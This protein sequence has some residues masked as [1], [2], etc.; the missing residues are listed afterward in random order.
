MAIA[1]CP[2]CGSPDI[3]PTTANR[4]RNS[5]KC[6][7][8]R[9]VFPLTAT[10]SVVPPAAALILAPIVAQELKELKE[11][12]SELNELGSDMKKWFGGLFANN[13][14]RQKWFGGLFA[15]NQPRPTRRHQPGA[16][17]PRPHRGVPPPSPR[18]PQ[19]APVHGHSPPVSPRTA[20][21]TVAPGSAT[22]QQRPNPSPGPHAGSPPRRPQRP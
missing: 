11:L 3:R 16:A 4:L 14:P 6:D 10:A 12:G 9:H 22:G 8:C 21:P 1:K 5:H 13:Q 2:R 7:S 18:P 19:Q 17:P 20:P 15:N